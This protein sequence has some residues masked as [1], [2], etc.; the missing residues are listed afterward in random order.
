ME[1]CHT[2]RELVIFRGSKSR[3]AG[4]L[5]LA[6][7]CF[8]MSRQN[9]SGDEINVW[10]GTSGNN[11]IYRVTLDTNKAKL[12][13]PTPA[14]EVDSAGFLAMHSNGKTLYS[15]AKENGQPGVAAFEIVI[16]DQPSNGRQVKKLSRLNF[17]PTG[18]GGAACVG[19]DR[20]G[21]V[22]MS[23]QYGGGSTTSYTI[24]S[25][26]SLER[27]V[28]VV[29]HGKGS[30]VNQRRQADSH[31][32][33]VGTSPDNKFLMVPDLGMD[34]VVVYSLD[35]NTGK[36]KLHSKVPV[37]PG[38]GPRHM[39]FHPSG[40]FAYVLNELALTVSVFEY[41]AENASF[42]EVQVIE[43]LPQELK[44]KR[45]DSAAEIRVHPTGEFVYTSNRGHD[46]ITVFSVD[47]D[48]GQLSFVERESIRGSWP[49]NFNLD[50]TGSWLIAAGARS[51]TLT[52]FEVD[53]E[54]GALE[55]T[56]SSVNMPSPI[57]VLFD[58]P[59]K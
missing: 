12:S 51:N 32:H 53:K 57:C 11:G 34:R 49:R 41:G 19:V 30:G 21:R 45:L 26:G 23:A 25:D 36:I 58:P 29:E 47:A 31:P 48:T 50:P 42:K 2:I 10:I 33:W 14:A 22:L 17:L 52:L 37:P 59:A 56:H 46:S 5:A 54:T 18:D 27:R 39:K 40:K 20:T 1:I 13:K 38:A 4:C 6:V 55:Y 7:F 28:N 8:L 15:T 44:T 16:P 9:L 35:E 3:L 24:K 43:T